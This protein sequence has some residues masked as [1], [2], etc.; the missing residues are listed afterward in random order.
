MYIYNLTS[1]KREFTLQFDPLEECVYDNNLYSITSYIT[2]DLLFYNF[3]SS[4]LAISF[5]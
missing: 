1:N 4:V 3:C 2:E 5:G